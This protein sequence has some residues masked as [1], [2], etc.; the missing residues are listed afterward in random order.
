MRLI[1][2]FPLFCASCVIGPISDKPP[3]GDADT[4]VDADADA[5]ADAD[6]DA[7][8]DAD[9]DGD[10]VACAGLHSGRYDGDSEGVVEAELFSDGALEMVFINFVDIE[11]TA[12]VTPD[13]MVSGS[14]LGHTIDGQY[15]FTDCSATGS[16][17]RLA[18]SAEGSWE[19][20]L[21]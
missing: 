6:V 20:L 8:A 15:D 16:W 5:D 2:L 11:A 9:A 12:T 13:G 14:D 1:G 21:Q 3:E 4:D 18:D 10:I 7:D 17:R 19:L